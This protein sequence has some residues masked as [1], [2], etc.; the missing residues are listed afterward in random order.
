M[1]IQPGRLADTLTKRLLPVYLVCGD[2][3]MQQQEAVDDIVSTARKH[4]YTVREIMRVDSHFD[5]HA[6]TTE[7]ESLSLFAEKKVLDLRIESG[8]PGA[9]GASTLY[10]YCQNMPPDNLLVVS[11]GKLVARDLKARWVQAI[12]NIGGVIQ[13]WPLQGGDLINW[14]KTRSQRKGMRIEADAVPLI[15]SRIEGNLLAAVQEIEKLFIIHGTDV[16]SRQD[17]ESLVADSARFDV[18]RFLDSLLAGQVNRAIR[19]LHGLKAE[20]VAAPVVLWGLSRE[21]RDLFGMKTELI[22]GGSLQNVLT[23]HRVWDKRKP[24]VTAA[25]ERLTIAELETIL[26]QCAKTDRQ[27]KGRLPGDSWESLLAICLML[28]SAQP[29]T[30]TV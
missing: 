12:D 8:K 19:I 2:E 10:A 6:L 3:P 25:L 30:E 17:I 27:I 16:I 9:E 21:A 4:G 24:L 11:C 22:Q 1:R 23:R 29:V 14:L 20:G 18:F 13:V 28:C 15:A 26:L 7:A 5:W